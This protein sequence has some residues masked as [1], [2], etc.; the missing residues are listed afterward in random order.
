MKGVL[1]L[2]AF[3]HNKLQLGVGAPPNSDAFLWE[4][5]VD[6]KFRHSEV[7]S[8]FKPFGPLPRQMLLD[9]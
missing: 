9:S 6:F 7:L 3:P 4:H 1:V 5:G 8:K 2:F